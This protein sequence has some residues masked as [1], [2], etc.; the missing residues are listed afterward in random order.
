MLHSGESLD[1]SAL[2]APKVDKHSTGG[3][4]DKTSLVIAPVLAAG[5]LYVPMISGRGLGHTGGTLD[6]LESIPGFNVNLSLSEFRRI[7]SQCGWADRPDRRPRSG[8]Q[9]ALRFARRHRH[10]GE[11]VPHLRVDHVQEA[12]R[13]PRALVLDV[14][15]GSGAFM[16]KQE[17]AEFLAELMVETGERMGKKMVALITDMD[18]PLGR[19]IGNALEVGECVQI[20]H[21]NHAESEDLYELTV[22]LCAWAFLLGN[23][24]QSLD[25]GK[26]LS[27]DLVASG[28]A[29]QKFQQM[30][31]LQGGDPRTTDNPALLPKAL[32]Q[33]EILSSSDGYVTSMQ[34][35]RIG[36]AGVML[37]GGRARKEDSIDPAVGF[38]LHKKVGDGVHKGEPV[39]TIH[40]NSAERYA[41]ARSVL[42]AAF[43]YGPE[44]PAA[45]SLLLKTISGTQA[46]GAST[47]AIDLTHESPELCITCKTGLNEMFRRRKTI[48]SSA[49]YNGKINFG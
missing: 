4:G 22:D 28:K 38:V 27:R 5:G 17:D 12:R 9:K 26:Q 39:C 19:T 37:G 46:S 8:R 13:R 44:K 24:V 29:W 43:C 16:K 41:S 31:E 25:E 2:P 10:R 6:K 47:S 23:R 1:F 45:R 48:F 42:E 35:E 49:D 34:C 18:Q 7:L 30:V 14:K 11:S 33:K 21:G 3:V 40:Y 32:Y 36:V 15:T 20:L